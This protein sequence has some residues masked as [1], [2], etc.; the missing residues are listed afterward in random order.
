MLMEGKGF[1]EE[2]LRFKESNLSYPQSL[3]THI[4]KDAIVGLM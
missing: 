3:T 1:N 2:T 4:P